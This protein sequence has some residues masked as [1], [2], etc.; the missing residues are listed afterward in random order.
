MVSCQ[1]GHGDAAAGNQGSVLCEEISGEKSS[2]ANRPALRS[3]A[4]VV[5][6]KSRTDDGPSA[7]QQPPTKKDD[8]TA[9]DSNA[10]EQSKPRMWSV[11]DKNAFFEALCEYG[12]DFESIQTYIAQ[13]NKKKS[14]PSQM[15]RKRDQVRHF[16]Y[17]TWHQISKYLVFSDDVKKATQEIYGLVNYAELR[18]KIGGRI[19]EK[20]GQKLNELVHKGATIIRC[21]GKNVRVKTPLCRAL[22]KLNNVEDQRDD[23]QPKLPARV[24][25]ELRPKT[26]GA[27]A[28]VQATSQNPRMRLTLTLQRRLSTVIEY[29]QRRWRP[30]VIKQRE[31]LLGPQAK[32]SELDN[33]TRALRVTP[34]SDAQLAPVNLKPGVGM[35]S[36][37]VCLQNY[38]QRI[39]RLEDSLKSPS[40]CTRKSTKSSKSEHCPIRKGALASDVYSSTITQSAMQDVHMTTSE[41]QE[42]VVAESDSRSVPSHEV[43]LR[44]LLA[45]QTAI[46]TRNDAQLTPASDSPTVINFQTAAEKF[47]SDRTR[48]P[49]SPNFGQGEGHVV[50]MDVGAVEGNACNN[51][52]SEADREQLALQ[53]EKIRRGWTATEAGTVTIGEIFLMLGSPTK[54]VLEYDWDIKSTEENSSNPEA[55]NLPSATSLH[56]VILRKL[57]N[58]ASSTYLDMKNKQEKQNATSTTC[59]CAHAKSSSLKGSKG[60]ACKSPGAV[61]SVTS[62]VDAMGHNQNLDSPEDAFGGKEQHQDVFLKPTGS[63]PHCRVITSKSLI[64]ATS[65]ANRVIGS[66]KAFKE[67]LNKLMPPPRKTRSRAAKQMVMQREHPLLPKTSPTQSMMTLR[68]VPTT[69]QLTSSFMPLISSKGVTFAPTPSTT[70]ILT[71]QGLA[72]ISAPDTSIPSA[73]SVVTSTTTVSALA[74]PKVGGDQKSMAMDTVLCKDDGHITRRTTLISGASSVGRHSEPTSTSMPTSISPPSISFLEMSLPV[75]ASEVGGSVVAES[76]TDKLLDF[77]LGNSSC[78]FSGLIDDKIPDGGKGLVVLSNLST[79]SIIDTTTANNTSPPATT[80]KML[81]TGSNQWLSGDAV[82]FSLSSLLGHLESPMKPTNTANLAGNAPPSIDAIGR[83]PSD[84]DSHLQCIMTESSLDYVSKFADLAAHIENAD[85]PRK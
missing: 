48:G 40:N 25:V 80:F 11:D 66:E 7:Q 22:K 60:G 16:Y 4:R 61:S 13:K 8:N 12:K 63:A 54:L 27:W 10:P 3:S 50:E 68:I 65:T 17:R 59:N 2:A 73:V 74:E 5:Q 14:H 15:I 51:R 62:T 28:Y 36:T 23:E 41:D 32:I 47:D 70:S 38:Q 69:P 56:S 81:S 45:L 85:L 64:P 52:C 79:D 71:T 9:I 83:L 6:K 34:C 76:S 35:S 19:D 30:Q 72:S 1:S 57:L 67:Q 18:K 84:V 24:T 33:D 82:D 37:S 75:M 21:K 29:L 26:N 58:L 44:Q 20:N 78:T 49:L 46:D 42:E 77:T 55:V 39:M 43:T 53:V 31:R